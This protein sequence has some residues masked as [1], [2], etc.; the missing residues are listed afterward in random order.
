LK[1]FDIFP[2]KVLRKQNQVRDIFIKKLSS[3]NSSDVS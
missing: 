2:Q 3:V 1:N